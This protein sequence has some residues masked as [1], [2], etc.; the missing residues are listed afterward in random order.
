MRCGHTPHV[1]PPGAHTDAMTDTYHPT[2]IEIALYIERMT[3]ELAG[4]A[5]SNRLEMLAYLLDVAREEAA[6]RI[7]EAKSAHRR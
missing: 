3:G 7:A 1:C 6:A 2:P 5:R 4:L